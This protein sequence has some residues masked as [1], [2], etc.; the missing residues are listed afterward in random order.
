MKIPHRIAIATGVI[1]ICLLGIFVG[2]QASQAVPVA[3]LSNPTTQP[4]VVN[5]TVPPQSSYVIQPAPTTQ[6]SSAT[7]NNVAT[8]AQFISQLAAAT[9]TPIGEEI[10]AVI[11][12]GLVVAGF[13][14]VH[15]NTSSTATAQANATAAT[16]QA[17]TASHSNITGDLTKAL[18]AQTAIVTPPKT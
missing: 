12:L 18:T 16:V 9:S 11:G 5:V 3:T 6:P 14:G 4:I 8:D 2:C 7:A 10:S 15:A 13:F 1:V 17:I